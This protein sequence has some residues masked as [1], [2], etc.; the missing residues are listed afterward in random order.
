MLLAELHDKEVADYKQAFIDMVDPNH[1]LEGSATQQFYDCDI[2]QS[3]TPWAFL[4]RLRG[5]ALQANFTPTGDE[6]RDQCRLVIIKAAMAAE[7]PV[8]SLVQHD[9]EKLARTAQGLW[10]LREQR[11]STVPNKKRTRADRKDGK[12]VSI[13]GKDATRQRQQVCFNCQEKGHL[14]TGCTNPKKCRWCRKVNPDHEANNCPDHQAPTKPSKKK[15]AP[16][17]K[18]KRL[19]N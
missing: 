11:T 14:S 16:V 9:P 5:L 12:V 2:N 8:L 17:K 18:K 15:N 19:T 1:T 7:K 13:S 3:E 6:V 4:Q 10:D